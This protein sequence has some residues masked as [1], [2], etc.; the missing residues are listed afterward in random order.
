ME[1]N[2]FSI[3]RSMEGFLVDKFCVTSWLRQNTLWNFM[4]LKLHLPWRTSIHLTSSIGIWNLRIYYWIQKVIT[5]TVLQ[6]S[7]WFFRISK[8][9]FS[10]IWRHSSGY[11]RITDFGL[12][13]EIKPHEETTT[14]CGTPEY[15]GNIWCAGNLNSWQRL[16]CWRHKDMAERL[17]WMQITELTVLTGWLVVTGDSDLWDAGR[18]GRL[19]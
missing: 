14:F 7:S 1:G 5:A 11:I 17:N 18:I 12:S 16:N 10:E 3:W 8:S 15:I 13:K 2:Y 6:V 4:H 19:A 9:A